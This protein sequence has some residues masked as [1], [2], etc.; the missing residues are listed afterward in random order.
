MIKVV[1]LVKL[2]LNSFSL[3]CSA[4]KAYMLCVGPAVLMTTWNVAVNSIVCVLWCLTHAFLL[5]RDPK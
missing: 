3:L 4:M 5:L 1:K 2:N